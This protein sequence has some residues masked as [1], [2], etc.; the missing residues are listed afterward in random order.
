MNEVIVGGNAAPKRM[1]FPMPEKMRV[2]F[3]GGT[4]DDKELATKMIQLYI[5]NKILR[6]FN[7]NVINR[8]PVKVA[9]G[10]LFNDNGTALR[11][12]KAKKNETTGKWVETIPE[13]FQRVQPE[14]RAWF[15]DSLFAGLTAK[16]VLSDVLG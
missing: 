16:D 14:L 4:T 10:C 8:Q 11:L 9:G 3:L 13:Y 2:S 15:Q 6:Q 1:E 12:P 7:V 5:R